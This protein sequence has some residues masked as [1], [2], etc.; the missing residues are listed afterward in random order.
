MHL[1][2]RVDFVDKM[3]GSQFLVNFLLLASAFNISCTS[4][5]WVVL[6]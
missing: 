3:Q 1:C 4:V 5:V 6:H 2:E